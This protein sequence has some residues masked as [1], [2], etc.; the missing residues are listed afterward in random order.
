MEKPIC[1]AM[2][3][4]FDNN[5]DPFIAWQDKYLKGTSLS[6]RSRDTDMEDSESA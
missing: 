6:K 1:K 4:I 2:I 5:T 3:A